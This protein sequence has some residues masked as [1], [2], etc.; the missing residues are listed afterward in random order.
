VDGKVG[1]ERS[2][3]DGDGDPVVPGEHAVRVIVICRR[4]GR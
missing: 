3:G 1:D 2:K 4:G